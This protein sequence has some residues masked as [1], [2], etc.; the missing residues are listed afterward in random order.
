MCSE[1]AEPDHQDAPHGQS[2][3]SV[4]CQ[5]QQPARDLR[6]AKRQLLRECKAGRGL[7]VEQRGIDSAESESASRPLVGR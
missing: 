2:Q 5:V 6:V 1:I 3:R 4:W 7:L